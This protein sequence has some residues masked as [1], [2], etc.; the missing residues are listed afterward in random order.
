MM[1][2][3]YLA[4]HAAERLA[5]CKR[6][7]QVD[8]DDDDALIAALLNACDVYL[9]GAGISR[10][11]GNAGLYDIVAYAMTL[12]LYD[13]RGVGKLGAASEA[14]AAPTVRHMLTQLK[15]ISGYSEE[16]EA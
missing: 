15:L 11:E 6:Y 2:I 5:A 16:A 13:G 12:Q 8:F 14:A 10:T 4:A 9:L 7:L 1:D 3:A